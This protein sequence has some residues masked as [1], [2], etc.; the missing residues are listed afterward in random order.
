MDSRGCVSTRVPKV[1]R[2]NRHGTNSL[3]PQDPLISGGGTISSGPSNL[4]VRNS[5]LTSSKELSFPIQ[6]SRRTAAA[7]PRAATTP[8]KQKMGEEVGSKIPPIKEIKDEDVFLVLPSFA[9]K[10]NAI[11][12]NTKIRLAFTNDKSIKK[13][14]VRT[15]I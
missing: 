2:E 7:T 12:G 8:T 9:E 5:S 4:C 1:H 14:I 13:L 15:K 6:E 11:F 10:Y 3:V